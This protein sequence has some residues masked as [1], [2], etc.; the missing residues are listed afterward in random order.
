MHPE[1]AVIVTWSLVFII[2][3]LRVIILSNTRISPEK[4]ASMNFKSFSRIPIW[5]VLI[6]VINTLWRIFTNYGNCGISGCPPFKYQDLMHFMSIAT[7]SFAIIITIAF[8]ISILLSIRLRYLNKRVEQN[9]LTLLKTKE[10]IIKNNVFLIILIVATLTLSYLSNT[11][12]QYEN[13]TSAIFD[14]MTGAL[15]SNPGY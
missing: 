14:P 5:A 9:S 11:K 3:C 12:A 13:I 10:K 2:Y 1:K 4:L 6:L 15:I 7:Q 8:L